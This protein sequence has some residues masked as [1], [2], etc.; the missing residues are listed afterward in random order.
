MQRRN[1]PIAMAR[2]GWKNRGSMFSE[3]GVSLRSCRRDQ[4][5]QNMVLH[6]LTN[7]TVQVISYT[8]LNVILLGVI[9]EAAYPCALENCIYFRCPIII[10]NYHNHIKIITKMIIHFENKMCEYVINDICYQKSWLFLF[11]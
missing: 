11:Y 8:S 5:A 7:G 10:K 2:N 6:Y 3:F 4:S 9:H 1:Y